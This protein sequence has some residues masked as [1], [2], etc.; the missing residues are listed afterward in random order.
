MSE[1][2]YDVAIIGGGPAGMTAAIYTGRAHLQTCMLE[3]LSTGGQMF[4]TATIENYPGFARIDGPDLSQKM[5]AQA[6]EWGVEIQFGQVTEI[7]RAG[8]LFQ[9]TTS[10]KETVLARTIIL[11]TGSTPKKLEVPGEAEFAGKGVSYCATCDGAFFRGKDVAVVGG[12]DSAV[13]E[14]LYLTRLVNQVTII[15]RRDRLRATKHLQERA[16]TDPR[17]EF[18]WDSE[19]EAI[20]GEGTVKQLRVKNKKTDGVTILPV[21]GVFI[22]VGMRPSTEFLKGLVKLDAWGYVEAG[23]DTLTS[24]PGVFAAGDIRS[25]GLRQIVTAVADG[26]VAAMAAERYLG[27]RGL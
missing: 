10:D 23:E 18:L 6:K 4:N 13:E 7:Q 22:Y 8:E 11:A 1:A 26:A 25:K 9:V 12:G 16:F 2:I 21:A 20:E 3:G 17:I 27:K 15:H 24:M 5:E 19:V 14:S